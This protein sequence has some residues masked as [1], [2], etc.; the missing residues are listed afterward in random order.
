MFVE[1]AAPAAQ[2][3]NA[4]PARGTYNIPIRGIRLV[5]VLGL[6]RHPRGRGVEPYQALKG[7]LFC[8]CVESTNLT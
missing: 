2:Y 6:I 7:G 5:I 1:V 8:I 3:L 4:V